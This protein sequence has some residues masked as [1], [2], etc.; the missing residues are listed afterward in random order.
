MI[1]GFKLHTASSLRIVML[2]ICFIEMK[3]KTIVKRSA[4]PIELLTLVNLV[5]A[6]RSL[7]KRTVQV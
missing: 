4:K 5:K 3:Y 1:L 6:Y 2:F 7:P